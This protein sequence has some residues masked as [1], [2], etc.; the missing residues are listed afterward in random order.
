MKNTSSQRAP[1]ALITGAS[2]GIGRAVALRLAERG[3]RIAVNYH[4]SSS[5]AE[6][7]VKLAEERGAEAIAIRADVSSP[8]QAEELPRTVLD[9]FGQLD[10]LVNNAGAT[11]DKLILQ[12]S[13]SDWDAIWNL[14]LVGSRVIARRVLQHMSVLGGGRI[15]NMSSV[16]GALGNAGQANYTAA[17][18]AVHGLTRELALIGAPRGITVNCVV[19]GYVRTAATAHLNARQEAAWLDRIPMKRPGTEEEMADAVLF[20]IDA[21]YVT[22][23][24][25]A[26]DGGLLARSGGGLAS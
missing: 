24:C 16:V 12:M 22:G 23:Q 19:P 7:V 5:N 17:K 25:L 18:S 10:V 8:E 21:S 14:D 13:E 3:Y 20:F 4:E 26:V 9:A 6:M 2:R 1:V 15:V 11:R